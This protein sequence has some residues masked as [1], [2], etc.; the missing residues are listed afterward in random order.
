MTAIKNKIIM[1]LLVL[2]FS[3]NSF[4]HGS[5]E[6]S[7][8]EKIGRLV[9]QSIN[10]TSDEKLNVVNKMLFGASLVTRLLWNLSEDKDLKV[11]AGVASSLLIA[12]EEWL[13]M[14]VKYEATEGLTIALI[15]KMYKDKDWEVRA[16]TASVAGNIIGVKGRALLKK[17]S[18]DI[19]SRV[20]VNVVYAAAF[21]LN[22]QD[23]C[24]VIPLLKKMSNDKKSKDVRA[25]ANETLELLSD[26]IAECNNRN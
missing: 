2:A 7:F 4:A 24:K 11:R 10:G 22:H 23:D 25:A 18:K 9:D 26:K 6:E 21:S 13:L 16:I 3:A 8:N 5:P 14:G 17:M 19:N 15:E 12:M 20:R 1:C